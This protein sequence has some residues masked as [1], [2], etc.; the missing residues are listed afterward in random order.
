M[1]QKYFR[2]HPLLVMGFILL[3][4]VAS[5]KKDPTPSAPQ[6]AP[7]ATLG[8]YE[9]DTA[10]Y[11]RVF[12]AVTQI[13]TQTLTAIYPVFDTGSVGL[14]IDASGVIPATR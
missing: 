7:I 9:L 13:G 14:S 8:L 4:F 10:I 3:V 11:R 1:K 6:A 12:I 2:Q 5:C